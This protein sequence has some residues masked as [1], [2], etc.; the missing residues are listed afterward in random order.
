MLQKQSRQKRKPVRE[1][2]EAL[3]LLDELKRGKG[4]PSN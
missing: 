2:A 1:I 4:L 3:I